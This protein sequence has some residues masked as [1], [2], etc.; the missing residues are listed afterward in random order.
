MMPMQLHAAP[1][2]AAAADVL[3]LLLLALQKLLFYG[4]A[5]AS[6]QGTG[7]LHSSAGLHSVAEPAEVS[8]PGDDVHSREGM[9]GAMAVLAW[10]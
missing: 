10:R 7:L 3:P 6:V 1:A 9:F 4:A 2:Q 8:P 5:A